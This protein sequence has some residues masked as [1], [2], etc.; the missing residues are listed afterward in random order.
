MILR[1]KRYVMVSLRR[2][3]VIISLMVLFFFILFFITLPL[4]DVQAESPAER[5]IK[6]NKSLDQLDMSLAML[7][8]VRAYY[9]NILESDYAIPIKGGGLV[10]ITENELKILAMQQAIR[11]FKKSE[12]VFIYDNYRNN[13]RKLMNISNA[14]KNI[15]RGS[16]PDIKKLIKTDQDKVF[17]LR[18]EKKGITT[19]KSDEI[20]I[21]GTWD[22]NYFVDKKMV[23]YE[24]KQNGNS[25]SWNVNGPGIIETTKD[26]KI[27]GNQI[28]I[29]Y[30]R[31]S[32]PHQTGGRFVTVNG[33][34]KTN[35]NS[36]KVKEIVWSNGVVWRKR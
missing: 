30:K 13:L 36:N 28:T 23:T 19:Q 35:N 12:T 21:N 8:K 4:S 26:G 22:S 16:L 31:T 27:K 17:S 34:V 18:K 29:K 7:H 2:Y 15:A 24:I 3:E 32:G 5:L 10:G 20:N 33:T 1:K 14:A 11:E 25:F 9:E 6:I